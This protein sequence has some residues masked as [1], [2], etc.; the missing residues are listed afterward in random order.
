[1]RTID[2]KTY[3]R[4]VL[5]GEL[6]EAV[7]EF[8]AYHK[9]IYFVRSML[10]IYDLLKYTI[11]KKERRL[12]DFK[13]SSRR[14]LGFIEETKHYHAF[15]I[16]N[17]TRPHWTGKSDIGHLVAREGLPDYFCHDYW[18]RKWI[19]VEV[20]AEKSGLS[21][22]QKKVFEILKKKFDVYIFR[23]DLPEDLEIKI[24]LVKV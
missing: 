24:D 22:V 6:A 20:K 9:N 2:Q 4:Q 12:K 19:F 3:T 10:F 21:S 8:Y 11:Y 5:Y 7:F 18:K 23:V 15:L 13:P 14:I 17:A 1:M 16:E